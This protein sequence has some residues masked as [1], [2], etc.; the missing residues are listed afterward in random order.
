M[1]DTVTTAAVAAPTDAGSLAGAALFGAP[2]AAVDGAAAG[3]ETPV[4]LTP[5]EQAA[6]ELA[7]AEAAKLETPA[8]KRPGKDATPEEW[9]EF[10]K[11]IGAPDSAEAYE[12]TLPDGDSPENAAL[13]QTL[14]KEANILPEQAAKLL[15]IRN[16]IFSEQTA[17]AQK[18][19]ADRITALDSKNK[20]EAA[21]LTNEWGTQSTANMELARRG[22]TQFIAGDQAK[23]MQVISSMESV[24]GYK[25]TMKFWQNIG[26]S[27]GEHDAAGLGANNG[28]NGVKP[29]TA[30][31]LYSGTN[32]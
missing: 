32:K 9:A 1:T 21:D 13:I 12:V 8:V 5:E 18:S 22:V 31:L 6:K 10:Y 28:G 27:I 11:A 26:K 17:A 19:E 23:Q 4:A 20:A 2:D 16:K 30:E 24:L 25:E 7:A 15:E 14:F 3:A 29:S